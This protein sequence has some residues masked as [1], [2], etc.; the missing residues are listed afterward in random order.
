MTFLRSLAFL[1]A[2]ILVTPPYAIVAL[3]TFPLPRLARYRE[4][5]RAHV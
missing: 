4:I 2:Q 5:G 1:I 3:A